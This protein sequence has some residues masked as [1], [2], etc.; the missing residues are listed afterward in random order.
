MIYR[1]SGPYSLA[2]QTP[3][4]GKITHFVLICY[5][6]NAADWL[7]YLQ[8]KSFSLDICTV[9]CTSRSNGSEATVVLVY[10]DKTVLLSNKKDRRNREAKQNIFRKTIF[11]VMTIFLVEDY[12]KLRGFPTLKQKQLF[13]LSAAMGI[14]SH[15]FS[16]HPHFTKD[17]PFFIAID[18]VPLPDFGPNLCE[19]TTTVR[20]SSVN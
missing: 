7:M 5:A 10:A 14:P 16:F 6:V 4:H 17:A 2:S 1:D 12:I 15:L 3:E 18:N 11:V 8:K 13:L 20:Y 9:R 19:Q